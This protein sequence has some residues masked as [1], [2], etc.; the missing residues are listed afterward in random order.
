MASLIQAVLSLFAGDQNQ[1]GARSGPGGA[2]AESDSKTGPEATD[3]SP[4]VARLHAW[5]M[6]RQ[7][8]EPGEHSVPEQ[9]ML[10][11]LRQ[12]IRDR[13][14]SRIPRQPRVLP[15]LIRAL[16]DEHQ[17]H[18]DIAAIIL[19][20]PALTDELLRVVNRARRDPDQ[21]SIE[22][23]Q[24]AVL[25]VGVEGVRRAVS[26]AVM[27]PV[28]ESAS[29]AE[30]GFA[31][32]VWHWGLLCAN[33]CDL[34]GQQHHKGGSDLFMVGLMPS[35]AYLTLY[36]ELESIAADQTGKRNLTAAIVDEALR[37][38]IGPMLKRLVEAWQLPSRYDYHLRELHETPLGWA[39]SVLSKGMI[40]G[41]RETLLKAGQPTMLQRELLW[42]TRLEPDLVERVQTRMQAEPATD[43]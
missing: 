30:S 12:R 43:R 21:R 28:M 38:E 6:G 33:A 9:A 32:N 14:L 34:L 3:L 26:E 22:S 19:E 27:R 24:Q 23:V 10:T 8:I 11:E 18:R 31:R 35:L 17:T 37:R 25:M 29:R 41:T 20:E 5:L 13:R 2:A 36:R 42:V 40:L 15:L 1:G 16:G 39:E 4:E 7:G